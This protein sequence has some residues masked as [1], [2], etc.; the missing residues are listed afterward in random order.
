M[1]AGEFVNQDVDTAR[2]QKI[3]QLEQ[4]RNDLRTI[5]FAD[6]GYGFKGF[7]HTSI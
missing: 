6:Q 1:R 3:R 4:R 7:F 5:V 2:F